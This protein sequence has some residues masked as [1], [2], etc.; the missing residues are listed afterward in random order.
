MLNFVT[1]FII[2]YVFMNLWRYNYQDSSNLIEG[3]S[4]TQMIWYVT[5]T[6]VIWFG[7]RNH[8]LT[9]QINYDIKSG[10]IAYGMNKPYHYIWYIISKHLGEV[11]LKFLLFLT[12]G[13]VIGY[14]F[15]GR[16]PGFQLYQLPIALFSFFL[17]TLINSF[18]RMT[19]SVLSFWIEDSAPFQWIYDKMLIIIGIMFPVEMFPLWAQPIIKCSPIYVVTYGPAKLVIDFSPK[20]CL[21]VLTAQGIYLLVSMTVLFVF[22]R[23]GVKKLNVNGG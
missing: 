17:G 5:L 4:L 21:Q 23:K 8:T 19:I 16:V 3:Y 14:G 22:F 12:A 9:S 18:L 13:I 2:L 7:T 6:E 1:F 11:S 10:T 20:M 15:I